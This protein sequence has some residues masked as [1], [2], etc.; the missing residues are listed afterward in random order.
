MKKTLLPIAILLAC[1][2]CTVV[3]NFYT[4]DY[5]TSVPDVAPV[6]KTY[7]GIAQ[8]TVYQ[9]MPMSK[10]LPHPVYKNAISVVRTDY[11]KDLALQFLVALYTNDT[12]ISDNL[13]FSK[14]LSLTGISD[15]FDLGGTYTTNLSPGYVDV[16][17]LEA[18]VTGMEQVTERG[19]YRGTYRLSKSGATIA[20]GAVDG[21]VE[22]NGNFRFEFTQ[23]PGF[24]FLS[25]NGIHDE[26]S[27]ALLIHSRLTTGVGDSVLAVDDSVHYDSGDKMLRARFGLAATSFDTLTFNL[28]KQL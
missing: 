9:N 21:F 1:C 18:G 8:F 20:V 17:V 27:E 12:M 2:A 11:G 22:Y 4:D 7:P 13:I 24:R 28:S 14:P 5:E 26:V 15:T 6:V 16:R 3:D 10:D 19:L 25:G 23:A